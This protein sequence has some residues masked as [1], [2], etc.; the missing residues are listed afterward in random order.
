MDKKR[1]VLIICQSI[2]HAESIADALELFK[3][4]FKNIRVAITGEED[5]GDEVDCGDIIVATNVAGRGT[6]F[7]PT[8]MLVDM[9]G[10]HVIVGFMPANLRV[11][12]QARGRAGR[13][14]AAGSSE[15]IVDLTSYYKSVGKDLCSK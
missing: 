3:V 2:H 6:D 15:L 5:H 13:N 8:K 9:G 12:M 10:L 7:K 14:G 11:E 1:A 4:K